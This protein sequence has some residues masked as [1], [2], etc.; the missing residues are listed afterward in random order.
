MEAGCEIACFLPKQGLAVIPRDTFIWRV[1]FPSVRQ[2]QEA[3]EV[4][5]FI[6]AVKERGVRRAAGTGVLTS[7]EAD[8]WE[9]PAC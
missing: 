7:D 8:L 4:L 1:V 6:K 2:L 5:G 3:S 9:G